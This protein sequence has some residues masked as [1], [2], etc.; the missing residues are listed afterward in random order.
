MVISYGRY[1]KDYGEPSETERVSVV[2]DRLT[3]LKRLKTQSA[4]FGNIG[5][6]TVKYGIF[7]ILKSL[8]YMQLRSMGTK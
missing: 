1:G 5:D 3:I 7:N 4:P 6:Q 2:Y 8:P